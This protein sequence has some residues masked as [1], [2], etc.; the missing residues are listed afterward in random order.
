MEDWR[1]YARDVLGHDASPDSTDDRLLLRIDDHHHRL[2]VYSSDTEDVSSV[3]WQVQDSRSLQELAEG[4]EKAGMEVNAVSGETAS[5]HRVVEMVWFTDIHTGVR[6][7]LV[8]GPE[9]MFCPPV[10][11]ARPNHGFVTSDV[12]LGHIV[13]FV[14]DLEASV[15]FYVETLGFGVTDWAVA[16][17][18]HRLAAFLHCNSRHH[19]LALFFNPAASRHAQH[20][21]LE[22]LSIDD[23][24]V[25]HDICKTEDIVSVGLG[26]HVND[27][28]FSFYFKNPSGWHFEYGWNPRTIDPRTWK[29]EQYNV[30]QP[31]AGEWG[32][33]GLVNLYT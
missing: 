2:A 18:G 31:N 32:H 13:L 7:E 22:T 14:D 28:M 8:V 5:D 11:P 26:R 20:I 24:G 15:Q 21:M 3:M 27:R 1:A 10:A 23:V 29:V 19:S 9:M 30:L 12:G 4:I 6:T 33:E 17:G 25:T 16:P